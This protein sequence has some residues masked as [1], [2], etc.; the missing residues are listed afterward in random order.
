MDLLEYQAKELFRE[1]GIPVLPAQ[2]IE[3]PANLK[4]LQIP[5]PVVL[6]SQVHS[7]GRG[8]AGGVRFANNTIDAIA[9]ARTIFNLPIQGEYPQVILAE[10]HYD[11]QQEFFLAIAIDFRRKRPVLLG[12]AQGGMDL[13]EALEQM[14]QVLVDEEFSPYY[15]RRLALMIGLHGQQMLAV[16]EVIEKMYQLLVEKDLNSVEI[17]PLGIDANGEIMALDGKIQANDRAL[18]RHLDLVALSKLASE[19]PAETDSDAVPQLLD[20]NQEG[21]N[22]GLVCNGKNLA[23]AT[24]DLLVLDKG[25]LAGC[26]VVAEETGGN[27][28]PDLQTLPP[29]WN[30]AEQLK[31]AIAQLVE[32]KETEVVLVNLLGCPQVTPAIGEAIASWFQPTSTTTPPKPS[33]EERLNRPTATVSRSTRSRRTGRNRPPQSSPPQFVVRLAGAD[34]EGMQESLATLPIFLT[35][36]LEAAVRQTIFLAKGNTEKR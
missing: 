35:N 5:Y 13:E 36:D 25:K 16:S 7:G 12:S 15:A 17:N 24:W 8:K 2:R 28:L 18:G 23:L 20:W 27:L 4:R 6:K 1:V 3:D 26:A 14:Q 19:D 29:Q 21:G 22:I 32:D 10:A 31:Q 30:W 9:A 33:S 34:L 11:A